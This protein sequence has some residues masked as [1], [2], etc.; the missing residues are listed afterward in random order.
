M[1]PDFVAERRRRRLV[2]I[3][4]LVLGLAAAAATYFLISRPGGGAPTATPATRTIVVAAVEIKSRTQILPEMLT[5]LAVPDSPVFDGTATDIESVVGNI[6]LVNIP[7]GQALQTSLYGAGNPAGVTILAPGETVGPDSPLWRAVSI[8]VPNER[9]TGG[10][11]SAGDHVDVI[12]TL[13][14]ELYDPTGGLCPETLLVP[15]LKD[16]DHAG[17]LFGE[18][19]SAPTTKVTLTNIE[20]LT[21]NADDALYV[22]K[23]DEAQAEQIAHVQSS[24]NNQFTLTLRPQADTRPLD[25]AQFGQTTNTLIQFFG[26]K[27]PVLINVAASASP[28]PTVGPIPSETPLESPSPAP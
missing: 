14:P 27:L 6:A 7:K 26:F 28:G 3:F 20:V 19:Y 11:I 23:V 2:L 12:V 15:C 9:A 25:P 21:T 10:L 16:P 18:V 1:Q 17:P 13:N 5:T 8:Q 24:G 4:G 22:L